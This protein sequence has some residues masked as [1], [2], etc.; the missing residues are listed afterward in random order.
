VDL[1]L[2]TEILNWV[3]QNEVKHIKSLAAALAIFTLF[4]V[5]GAMKIQVQTDMTKEFPKDLP[6]YTLSNFVTD[7]FGGQD[8]VILAI[9]LSED[10]NGESSIK[11]IRDP[12][13][14]SY[15]VSL[16]DELKSETITS[17]VSSAG[18][19]FR[20]F[21][22]STVAKVEGILSLVPSLNSFFSSNLKTTVMYVKADLGGSESKVIELEDTI[23]SKL[24][25]V[26]RPPGVEVQLTGNPPIRVEIFK[27]LVSDAV[28][29]FILSYVVIFL[30]ILA[31][32]RSISGAVIIMFPLTLGVIWTIGTLGWLGI[33]LSIATVG[34]GA[35]IL[36]LGIEYGAFMLARFIE[37]LELGAE[38]ALLKSVPAVG[39][40][41]FGSAS[42]TVVGFVALTLSV[43]PMLQHL[44]LSL[45]LG[46]TYAF[47]ATLLVTPIP[48]IMWGKTHE[49]KKQANKKGRNDGNKTA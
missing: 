41:I 37:H 3:S 33:P 22:Y 49:Q 47:F 42:T 25:K 15:L 21:D 5:I 8:T 19:V 39:I 38:Q 18:T 45:A 2:G 9:T 23:H 14:I 34:I 16:E 27:L 43:M 46:I 31:L 20:N 30:K 4:M 6:V 17:D 40:A 44:G 12:Q 13:V 7:K 1:G 32:Q 48:L 28:Y 35:M 10:G 29:T 36:G 24:E 26:P 11:D